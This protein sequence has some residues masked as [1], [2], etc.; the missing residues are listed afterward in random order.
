MASDYSDHCP[1]L[2]G[3][4]D[5]KPGK[6]RFHFESF[7][8]KLDGFHETV[9]SAWSS[10]PPGPCPF[11]SLDMKFKAVTKSLQSW[12]EKR[13]GRITTQLALAKEILHQFEIAQDSRQLS[14]ELWL[15]NNLKKHSLALASLKRTMA[16]SRSRISWLKDGDA[17]THLF[18]LHARH[19]KR[20]KFIGKLLSGDK[21]CTTHDEKAAV[22]DEYFEAVLG[23]CTAR[24]YTINLAELGINA[25]DLSDLELPF[26]EE[27]V[28]RTI[29][30]LPSDKAPGPD[31]Y[32]GRFYK[33]CW[34]IIKED[35]M[36][37]I[38]AV[39]SRKLANFGVLNSAYITLLP[40]REGAE[41][42]KDFRPISLVHSFAKLITKMLSNRLASRLQQ[43][44]SLIQSAFIKG[45][46]I[47]DNFMLVQQ[48]AR[49]LNQQKQARILLK[50]DISKAFDS[51]AWPFLEIL[52]QLGFG[53][54]WR[55]IISGL[56]CSS[57]T[58][59]LLNGIPRDHIIHRRGLRQGDPLSPMLFILVM[60]V[61]G[62]MISK[63]K[64]EGLL[65]PLSRRALQ[66]RISIYADDVVLFLRPEGGDINLTM[67]ILD[68]F[69]EATG[70]RTNLQ[71]SNV[72]PIRCGE[73][74]LATVQN[75][76]P[77]ELASFPCKYL[78]LP[79]SLKK[80]TNE[81]V[82][83]IIDRIA[84][85]LPG[86]K[87]NLMTKIGRKVQ[88]QFVLTGM[89][90]YVFMAIDFPPWAIKAVDKIRHGFLWKGRR[91]VQGGH[92]LVAWVKV[93]RPI[94]LGGLGIADLKSLGWALRMRWLWLQ[95]T[96]PDRPWADL[97][98]HVHEQV[99]VFFAAAIYSEV[100]DGATTLFWTDRWL[101]GQCIADV[102]PRLFA[103]IAV[104][105]RKKRT[106][107]EALTNR[108]WI[109]DIRGAHMLGS[110]LNISSYGTSYLTLSCSLK[111]KIYMYGD[112]LQMVNILLNQLMRAYFWDLFFSGHGKKF[113]RL[114]HSPN[115]VSLCGWLLIIDVGQRIV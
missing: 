64:T 37:A 113:G 46:F 11:I 3:L 97:P 82:Q 76:L 70:L 10:V 69:G 98:I 74:E 45:R 28:W 85:Q 1:L 71:K 19:R 18:H 49:F 30:Q 2:L 31:G 68:L 78:G 79:L 81:Q 103:V 109:S 58:Q 83:P 107:K 6:R 104:R 105:R 22:I 20:K 7:W 52:Q 115:V 63:A 13:V 75:L 12:S 56:L 51:V 66:H 40:K 9:A 43:M 112:L 39:W 86:W 41:Q 93:C 106:L 15:K 67:S 108:A 17:N 4:Q 102:A 33:A 94:K 55:D 25:H 62:H 80:L 114:G 53:Q 5:N 38:S 16:R 36:A 44:V 72:L 96:E 101:H 42:P 73:T 35:I 24:E 32:T 92:C 59:V 88:V 8:P 54:I 95:K 48:T 89:L 84:D 29:K 87:A 99:R 111:W 100:G 14:Q 91:D 50:L 57:S 77:C 27:E 21:I 61:L 23:N 47:Q 65:M 90:I 60:H 34:A 26:T 110:S